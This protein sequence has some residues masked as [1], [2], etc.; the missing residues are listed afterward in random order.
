LYLF[1]GDPD[2][3]GGNTVLEMGIS[4]QEI[5][6]NCSFFGDFGF[7]RISLSKIG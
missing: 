2:I 1:S 6:A 3:R 5:Q 7:L 4:E